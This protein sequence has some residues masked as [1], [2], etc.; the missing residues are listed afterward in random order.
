MYSSISDRDTLLPQ[1]EFE[2]VVVSI[3]AIS[4]ARNV[5]TTS[6]EPQP[7]FA[8]P[9]YGYSPIS[10]IRPNFTTIEVGGLSRA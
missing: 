7:G 3:S 2:Q 8:S 9:R 5:R 6:F 4:T 1:P 10:F